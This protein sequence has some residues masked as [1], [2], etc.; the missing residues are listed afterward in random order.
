[1]DHG[2]GG[3]GPN[4]WDKL[5]PLVEWVASGKAPDGIV[6][7]HSTAEWWTTND[8]SVPTQFT[9]GLPVDRMILPTGW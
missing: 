4:S 9:R 3:P 6:A 1:M 7:T 5:A 2:R 8:P